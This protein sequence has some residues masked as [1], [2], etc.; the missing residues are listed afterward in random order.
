MTITEFLEARIAEDESAA[1]VCAEAFPAP[2]DVEDRGHSAQVTSGEPNFPPVA[3][4]DQRNESPGRWPGEHLEH[5]A[6]WDPA[7]VMAECA[8][9][10]SL[11]GLL[12]SDSR[13]PHNAMRREWADEILRAF[14]TVHADHP[15]YDVTWACRLT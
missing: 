9:K 4:I 12:Q 3:E 6:R 15:D 1:R 7:R 14:A 13:D 5:I 8:A 11:I 10:R 2:W